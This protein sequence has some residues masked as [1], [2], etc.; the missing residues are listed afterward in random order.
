[1]SSLR[2]KI[3]MAAATLAA[4]VN[5]T[6]AKP[7]K[8]DGLWGNIQPAYNTEAE[9][10]TVRLEGGAKLPYRLSTYGFMDFDATK[11]HKADVENV[12]V[13]GRLNY[14][15]GG[16]HEKLA[17]FGVTAEYNGGNGMEDIVRLGVSSTPPIGHGN[18]T[19]IKFYPC[20]T[21][22]RV[23]PQASFFSEQDIGKRLSLNALADY[24]LDPRTIYLE[25]GADVKLT[26]HL[27]VFGQ[28]RG[29]GPIGGIVEWVPIV[30]MKYGF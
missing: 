13:E 22:G 1:M 15:L 21:S 14:S 5:F 3:T 19:F 4:L 27:K 26:D 9:H 20:E 30:G 28:G 23:G 18:F 6:L 17:R 29:F 25:L 8:A 12:Y 10:A 2:T 7:A 24:N 16:I 11:E